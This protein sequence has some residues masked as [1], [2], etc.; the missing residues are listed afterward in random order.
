MNFLESLQQLDE[1]LFIFIEKTA[2][3][4]YLDPFML[5]LRNPLTWIPL[6]VFILV[7]ITVKRRDKALLFLA[8]TLLCFALADF[9][10]ASILKPM[11][12]RLRP[13]YNPDLQVYLR[14]LVGCGGQNGFPSSHA[15]NH[16]ALAAFWFGSM[17]YLGM[18]WQHW[19]WVWIWA[20]MICYAQVY[21]GKHYPSD[22]L[23]GAAY[24]MSIGYLVTLLFTWFD[25][26]GIK[27]KKS[28]RIETTASSRA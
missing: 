11:F 20:G 6:Y 22:V 4:E 15:T 26:N 27:I 5:L 7:Y 2:A 14:N 3:N 21:V 23:A 25:K 18:K 13:C 9:S 24:G 1:Q 28:R 17:Q 16:F 8:G 12:Q 10:S 19:L